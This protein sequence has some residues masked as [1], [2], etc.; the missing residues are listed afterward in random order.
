MQYT[1][2]VR[3]RPCLYVGFY[4]GKLAHVQSPPVL[5]VF[6]A[7]CLAVAPCSQ[8]QLAPAV[9]RPCVHPVNRATRH[10]FR[11]TYPR[12][13]KSPESRRGLHDPVRHASR[14]SNR[15]PLLPGKPHSPV[16]HSSQFIRRHLLMVTSLHSSP[17]R[18]VTKVAKE[19]IGSAIQRFT[20]GTAAFI[21]GTAER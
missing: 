21:P 10:R 2:V 8:C 9:T 1:A 16:S 5:Q 7:S 20:S 18:P 13:F 6:E 11:F 19:R 4:I 15:S 17:T 12:I 3:G 14:H